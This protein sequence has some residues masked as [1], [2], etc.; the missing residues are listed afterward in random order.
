LRG[1]LGTGDERRFN[2]LVYWSLSARDA[3]EPPLLTHADSLS[4]NELGTIGY[5]KPSAVLFMLQSE[6]GA[7]ALDDALR[8]YH[9]RWLF[10]HP[11][12]DD[13]FR[14]VED[15]S[16]RDLGWFWDAWFRTPHRMDV[17]V[18]SVRRT[19]DGDM[20]G[21]TI[22][23]E[24][25]G[26]ARASF[27]VRV[28]L[29]DG[30]TRDVRVGANDWTE[31]PSAVASDSTRSRRDASAALAPVAG[32]YELRVAGLPH[33]VRSVEADPGLVLLERSHANNLWPRNATPA[34]PPFLATT[35]LGYVRWVLIALL[36]A[37]AAR[38]AGALR[39][40]RR[41]GL[42]PIRIGGRRV[43]LWSRAEGVRPRWTR[44]PWLFPRLSLARPRTVATSADE[45]R[46]RTALAIRGGLRGRIALGGCAVVLLLL[47]DVAYRFDLRHG[48]RFTLDGMLA[49]I[50]MATVLLSIW[51]I[52]PRFSRGLFRE[53]PLLTL[54][55]RGARAERWSAAHALMASSHAGVRPSDWDPSLVEWLQPVA[56]ESL[57]AAGAALLAYYHALDRGDDAESERMLDRADT[58]A[59]G[60]LRRR[61]RRIV[62]AERTYRHAM[63]GDVT[64]A[65]AAHARMS[66]RG[67]PQD[68]PN[69]RANLALAHAL[70]D[71]AAAERELRTA[72]A[73][74]DRLTTASGA[75]L[76]AM[77]AGLIE[78]I[79]Q[80]FAAA[81]HA[82]VAEAPSDTTSP[83]T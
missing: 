55:R 64:A 28:T 65:A 19:R 60:W 33:A 18:D 44:G 23:L 63:A 27:I 70:G 56:D 6:I 29:D 71:R 78:A 74:L 26:L 51:A 49:L 62:A 24:R 81:S 35:P 2:Q 11:Y 47:L 75:G 8:E 68:R 22:S 76:A 37:F 59:R 15:V 77:E 53:A 46:A 36:L 82:T 21:A 52:R 41:A 17:A 83:A 42:E 66:R 20:H 79:E 43:L 13:F 7:R 30:S 48:S 80:R 61:A 67:R 54:G 32:R 4:E 50:V 14:T 12:P 10:R 25:R 39:G 58:L 9:R 72:R 73:Q 16:G 40:F 3:K 45:L 34:A 57:E 69:A 31:L 1:L 38:C 5:M